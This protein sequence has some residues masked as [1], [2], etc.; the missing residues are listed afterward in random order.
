VHDRGTPGDCAEFDNSRQ[1]GQP[2]FFPLDHGIKADR[3]IQLPKPTGKTSIPE[4]SL[5]MNERSPFSLS[6]N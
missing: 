4:S 3:S 6:S 1:R 5:K 2:A